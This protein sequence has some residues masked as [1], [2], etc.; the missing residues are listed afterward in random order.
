MLLLDIHRKYARAHKQWKKSLAKADTALELAKENVRKTWN[1]MPHFQEKFLGP[2]IKELEKRFP[3]RTIE[4]LGP[5][6]I[7]GL[8]S[9]H[10][11]KN[12]V[13]EKKRLIGRNCLSV[14]FEPGDGGKP[15]QIKDYSK[16][17]GEF[18]KET[19]GE[20]NGMNHPRVDIPEN[21]DVDWLIKNWIK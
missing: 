10:L 2:L 14:T 12:G 5:F 16:N 8:T 4:I 15:P 20:M 1:R 11:Y 6:G 21:A 3:D 17:T 7:C 13:T 19:I 9:L 18:R